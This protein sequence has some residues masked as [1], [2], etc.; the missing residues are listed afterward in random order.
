MTD[1]FFYVQH[2]FGVGHLRRAVVLARAMR[3]AGLTVRLVSGGFP[4]PAL[5]LDDLDPVQLPPVRSADESFKVL[6]DADGRP[7]DE[8][9]KARRREALLATFAAA[10][11]KVL[12]TEMFPFGRRQL[13]FELLPLLDAAE[14][15]RPRPWIV[16][17]VRD[18]LV[19][20]PAAKTAWMA[21]VAATR[22]DRVL[23]HGDPALIPFAAT[24]PQAERIADKLAYTGYVVERPAP[25]DP[26]VDNDIGR[27]EVLVSTGG[28][29]FGGR[30]IETALA[31]RPLSRLAEV[32][33]RILAGHNLPAP[34]FEAL[35]DQ[36]GP[37]VTLERARG[38]FLALLGRCRLSISQAGYNTT[39]ETLRAGVP[40]VLVP[41]AGG[42]E[43]EQLRRARLLAERGA[44][45]LAEEAGLTPARLAAAI[46]AADR[47]GPPAGPAIAFDGGAV[48]AEIV[49]RLAAIVRAS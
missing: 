20:K 30:L 19:E 11:P 16:A 33:W 29:A 12:L 46:D 44:I 24:F 14:R 28:G 42:Q 5:A 39:V 15:L 41:F 40:A 43:S 6:L 2:L 37:G 21:E 31:A 23:I 9:W 22:Y 45:T 38:D 8:A 32:P 34:V 47:Q 13:R 18:V 1:V 3:R 17:S 35:R 26:E 36:A 4:V 25:A 10:A 7:I 27:G 48:S 49:R